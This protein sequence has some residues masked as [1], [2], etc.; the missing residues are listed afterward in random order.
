MESEYCSGVPIMQ[1]VTS[2]TPLAQFANLLDGNLKS[3][4]TKSLQ[5]RFQSS[6]P[7]KSSS[8]GEKQSLR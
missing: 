1:N 8:A 3:L 7:A 4:T 6:P 5:G 2:L